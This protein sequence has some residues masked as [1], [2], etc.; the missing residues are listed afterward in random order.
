MEISKHYG[1]RIFAEQVVKARANSINFTGFQP[2]L[3]ILDD[4]IKGHEAAVSG[5]AR[6]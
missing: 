2:L 6:P 1:K 3:K 5:V 4:I